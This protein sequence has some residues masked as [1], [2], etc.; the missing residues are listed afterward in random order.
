MY[1]FLAL[2]KI[3]ALLDLFSLKQTGFAL[4]GGE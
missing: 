2:E 3:E 4:L 1:F